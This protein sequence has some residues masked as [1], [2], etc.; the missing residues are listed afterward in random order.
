MKYLRSILELTIPSVVSNITVPL[1]SLVDT[2]IVGHM[3]DA[4]NIG[5]IYIGSTIFSMIYWVFAFLRMGTTGIIAQARGAD[6]TS[7]ILYGLC[8]S[9]FVGLLVSCLLC[10]LQ[11]PLLWV[12]L[13]IVSPPD[14]LVASYATQYFR[15]CIWG[16]PAMLTTYCLSGWFIG[17]RDTRTPMMMAITQNVVNIIMSLLFVYVLH[18][19]IRGVAAG[20]VVGLYSGVFVGLYRLRSKIPIHHK[21]SFLKLLQGSEMWRFVKVNHDLFLRTICLVIVTV[22]FTRFS[23]QLGEGQLNANA[24]TMQFF[25]FYSY[26]MDGLANA[27][28]ALSG[29]FWG[30]KDISSLCQLVNS[31]FKVGIILTFA[32]MILYYISCS[33]IIL[34]LT[35]DIDVF[36]LTVVTVRQWAWLIPLVSFSAFIW[37]GVFIGLTWSR[38][39]LLSTFTGLVVFFSIHNLFSGLTGSNCL[40]LSFLLYL[41]TRGF[42]Q[43]IIWIK[44]KPVSH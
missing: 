27:G 38:G 36:R 23:S 41:A 42:V 39:M 37:D 18:A 4:N 12:A 1:L 24:I 33:P 40:W 2:S 17:M 28:E 16:A 31:L 6:D 44:N 8:R 14:G 20:T 43:W 19:D 35:N 29:E 34:L 26:F 32:F 10:I 7:G 13:Q 15:V 25:I 30:K 21:I 9:L 22:S 11:I 3:S 5:G